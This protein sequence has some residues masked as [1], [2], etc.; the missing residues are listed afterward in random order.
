MSKKK[1]HYYFDNPRKK[2]KKDK[3]DKKSAYKE[4]KLKSVKPSLDNKDIKA[5]RKILRTPVEVPK[6]FRKNR[7]HCNHAGKLMT[8][9][10][11]KQLT[12]NYAAYTPALDLMCRVFGEENLRICG[13][14]YDVLVSSD[15]VES[16]DINS[17]V[18][19]LYG[20]ANAALTGQRLKEKEIEEIAKAR[21]GLMENWL[22]IREIVEKIAEARAASE[23]SGYRTDAANLNRVEGPTV[24]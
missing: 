3:K 17:A 10:K 8:V 4:P 15:S 6:Q 9:E 16:D 23:S 24:Y 19:T 2:G 20:A 14:C 18:A 11:Y 5:G 21:D 13:S 7:E 1:N 12:P 22:F